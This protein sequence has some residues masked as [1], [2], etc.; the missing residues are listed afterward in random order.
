MDRIDLLKENQDLKKELEKYKNALNKTC[1]RLAEIGK[2]TVMCDHI[3]CNV[4]D[5]FDT[6]TC[7]MQCGIFDNWKE[8]CFKDE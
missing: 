7:E 2:K 8:W 3:Y 5:K 4:D 6:S 1:E